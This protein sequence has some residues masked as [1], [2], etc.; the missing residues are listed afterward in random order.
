MDKNWKF[1]CGWC[2]TPTDA[3]GVPL[4]DDAPKTDNKT[5]CVNGLCCPEGDGLTR[6]EM[7]QVTHEMAMDAQDPSL[8]G[9]W[10]EW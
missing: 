4:G 2:G 5:T 7:A 6:R 8:E 10:I 9:Q 1:R 3:D